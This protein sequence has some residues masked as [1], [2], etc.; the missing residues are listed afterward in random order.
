MHFVIVIFIKPPYYRFPAIISV[1]NANKFLTFAWVNSI[2][3]TRIS[4]NS[5]EAQHFPSSL[6]MIHLVT[7]GNS[8][9][10]T[11]FSLRSSPPIIRFFNR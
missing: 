11:Q 3:V 6:L 8:L 7:C 5:Y 9:T 4:I 10:L 2:C 1:K